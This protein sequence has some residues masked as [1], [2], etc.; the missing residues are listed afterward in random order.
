MVKRI[1]LFLALAIVFCC[2][3]LLFEGAVVTATSAEQGFNV[4]LEVTDEIAV[5]CSQASS[6]YPVL[7][8]P[9]IAGQTGGSATSTDDQFNCTTT[10]NSATGY[11]LT[12][13]ATST[14]ALTKGADSFADLG[15]S[16]TYNFSPS[17]TAA[18][19]EFGFSAST[20]IAADIV[21]N[22]L[23]N[24]SACN[25]A[26]GN[27]SNVHCWT[28]FNGTTPVNVINR[29]TNT[30]ADGQ[31]VKFMFKAK[32]GSTRNQPTG[33]YNAHVIVTATNQ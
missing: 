3:F 9:S 10:S 21:Q 27:Q 4:S 7:L 8:T 6:T 1:G 23:N 28:A 24:G 15:T 12:V 32:V 5:T 26:G 22:F 13:R 19:S 33:Y 18:E 17:V 31:V 29:S 30:D 2:S 16:P 11:T 25:Q 20:T 14:P